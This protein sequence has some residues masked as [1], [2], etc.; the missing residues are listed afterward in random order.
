[1]FADSEKDNTTKW[2]NGSLFYS[3]YKEG[4][5]RLNTLLKGKAIWT[6]DNSLEKRSLEMRIN[7]Q[8]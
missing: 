2:P 5:G 4:D 1:L 7:I 3:E 6:N 8:K